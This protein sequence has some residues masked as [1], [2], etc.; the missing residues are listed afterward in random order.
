MKFCVHSMSTIISSETI[1]AIGGMVATEI[2]DDVADALGADVE[3]RLREVI[4]VCCT[5]TY[6][7]GTQEAMK[8]MK[9]GKRSKLSCDDINHSLK[10]TTNEV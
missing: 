6:H 1:K 8:F 4:H 7:D 5:I 3:Y 9:H 2:Q 10:L